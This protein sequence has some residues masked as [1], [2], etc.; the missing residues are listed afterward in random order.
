MGLE[1]P[2]PIFKYFF[3]DDLIEHICSE[4]LKYVIHNNLSNPI[5]ITP[6]DLQK[7]IGILTLIS[8]GNLTNVRN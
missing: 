5:K 3:I 7:Y 2:R 1:T 4:F 6:K 8:L